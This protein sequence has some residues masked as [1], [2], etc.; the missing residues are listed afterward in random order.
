MYTRHGKC[1]PF[2]SQLRGLLKSQHTVDR[3]AE[4]RFIEHAR[5]FTATKSVCLL[6]RSGFMHRPCDGR[7]G[8]ELE[9]DGS[10][11]LACV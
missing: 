8:P 5:V 3:V 10:T 9:G 11:I 2:L 1:P 6:D 7:K 4:F